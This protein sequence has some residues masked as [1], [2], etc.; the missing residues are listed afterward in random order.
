M[1]LDFFRRHEKLVWWVLLPV[2]VIPFLFFYGSS[3]IPALA[4]G[5]SSVAEFMHRPVSQEEVEAEAFRLFG[6]DLRVKERVRRDPAR[7]AVA[8]DRIAFLEAARHSGLRVS[9]TEVDQALDRLR[10][11][12]LALPEAWWSFDGKASRAS[13]DDAAHQALWYEFAGL[14][15][16]RLRAWTAGKL[17]RGGFD[18][19]RHTVREELLLRRL[20]LLLQCSAKATDPEVYQAYLD[21]HTRLRA[22]WA[23]VATTGCAPLVP[24]EAMSEEAVRRLW[25]ERKDGDYL[26]PEKVLVEY[27]LADADRIE[28][29]FPADD[30]DI[31]SYYAAHRNEW[32]DPETKQPKP[33][34][35]VRAEVVRALNQGKVQDRIADA[36]E[37]ALS[38]PPAIPFPELAG[39][40]RLE[41]GTAGFT[42]GA[43]PPAALGRTPEIFRALAE[44]APGSRLDHA[45]DCRGGRGRSVVRLLAREP[46]HPPAFEEARERAAKDLLSIE[47]RRAAE[48]LLGQLGGALASEDWKAACAAMAPEEA[49]LQCGEAAPFQ[50]PRVAPEALPGEFKGFEDAAV[51]AFALKE[52][53]EA[54]RPSFSEDGARALVVSLVEKLPPEPAGFIAVRERLMTRRRAQVEEF[55]LECWRDAV[56][57][58]LRMP[59]APREPSA[60]PEPS[61]SQDP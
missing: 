5:G 37:A 45:L 33:L 34:E 50:S 10:T 27:L 12:A 3:G 57:A 18:D 20:S 42:E 46:A 14:L 22:R 1:L 56:G 11:G 40:L 28:G 9:E 51:D 47:C 24:K 8:L 43:E 30:A 44:S 39:R 19:L 7:Q 55:L 36:V 31:E 48:G 16:H 15:Q 38:A 58:R 35:A 54:T 53:G 2:T 23:S 60:A 4:G 26:V 13:S 61:G 32:P 29:E 52:R 25:E 17:T 21:E 41:T 6:D 59:G 49:A